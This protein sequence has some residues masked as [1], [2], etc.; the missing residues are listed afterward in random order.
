MC[1]SS[2][3]VAVA[4]RL[5]R[6]HAPPSAQIVEAV[7][8][9][10][11]GPGDTELHTWAVPWESGLFAQLMHWD[12][13]GLDVLDLGCGLGLAGCVALQQGASSIFFADRS[14]VAVG[15]ALRSA[16]ENAP[17]GADCRI[18]GQHGS[19]SETASWPEVDL[20]LGNELLYVADACEELTALIL[21]RVLR[22]GGVAAF[23]GCDRGLWDTFEQNLTASG[24]DVR[25][26]NGFAAAATDGAA[27]PT[28]LLIVVKPLARGEPSP[29]AALDSIRIRPDAWQDTG[30]SR[31]K[32]APPPCVASPAPPPVNLS[33]GDSV[34]WDAAP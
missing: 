2:R 24:L 1:E 5:L 8:G 13:S 20:I 9:C 18:S 25:C 17:L 30:A 31:A 23:C 15:L 32:L 19:W 14:E 29:P 33:S 27:I 26:G 7:G 34:R 3:D 16:A 10:T 21:S 22:P 11:D 6:L 28:V 4:G 12:L